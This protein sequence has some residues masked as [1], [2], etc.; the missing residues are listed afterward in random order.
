MNKIALLTAG[1]AFATAAL[2]VHAADAALRNDIA[3]DYRERLAALFE[4]FHRNPEL[5]GR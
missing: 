1:V 3:A 4:H 5:S 2:D